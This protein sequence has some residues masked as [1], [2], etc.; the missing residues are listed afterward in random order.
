VKPS[1]KPSLYSFNQDRRDAWV[2]RHAAALPVGTRVLDVGAGQGRYRA[3]F[4]HCVY[5][6]QDFAEYRGTS[7]GVL[8]ENWDYG[9]LDYICDASAI[10]VP[11]GSFDAI[12]CTEVLEHVPEPIRVVGEI[13]RI[14]RAGG[15][16]FLTAPLSSGLHQQ[17]YHFYGG[18]TPYFYRQ[19]L[20]AAGL[21]IVTIESNGHFFRLLMQEMH[22]GL[23]ILRTRRGWHRWHPAFWLPRMCLDYVLA[24]WLARLDDTVPV[25]EFTVGYMVEAVKTGGESI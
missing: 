7:G 5:M 24:P 3:L 22:R 17:P 20:S 2:A 21:S 19:F 9:A 13:A 15:F 10:P 23:M 12:L 1:A 11:D 4:K 14:L 8:Q 18:F 25:D 6:T 16:L